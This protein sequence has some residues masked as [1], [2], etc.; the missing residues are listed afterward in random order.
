MRERN[1]FKRD[2]PDP[3]RQ[4]ED[5][6]ASALSEVYAALDTAELVAPEDAQR[7]FVQGVRDDVRAEL[8]SV[9]ESDGGPDGE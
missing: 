2:L 3:P 6:Y 8:L 1:S 4:S 5:N 9:I 7:E